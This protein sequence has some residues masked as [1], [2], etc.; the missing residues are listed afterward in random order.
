MRYAAFWH[1]RS[2]TDAGHEWPRR[3]IAEAASKL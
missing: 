2:H 1:D 3:I